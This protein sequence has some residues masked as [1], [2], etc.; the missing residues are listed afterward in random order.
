VAQALLPVMFIIMCKSK[1]TQC[2]FSLVGVIPDYQI[3]DD[4]LTGKDEILDYAIELID[5]KK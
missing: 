5:K 3:E 1:H 4:P 2:G